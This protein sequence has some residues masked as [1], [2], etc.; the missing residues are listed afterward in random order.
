MRLADAAR[1]MLRIALRRPLVVIL[2][3][4]VA[5][6]VAFALLEALVQATDYGFPGAYRL[7]LQTEG[8]LPELYGYA[9]GLAITLFLFGAWRRWRLHSAAVWAAAYLYLTLDDAF[10][11]HER[12]GGVVAR[13]LGEGF[14]PAGLRTQD[15]GELMVYLTFGA[16]LLGAL[17]LVERRR[18]GATTTMLTRLMLPLIALLAYFA[19]AI[20]IAF[21]DLPMDVMIEDGG[22]LVAL[23]IT[24]A[25]CFIWTRRAAELGEELEGPRG[26]ARLQGMDQGMDQDRDQYLT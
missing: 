17:V 1:A 15:F 6:D 12:L 21:H 26:G 4:M 8:G 13:G 19:V 18:G 2:A 24:A 10:K 22:E 5:A 11:I 16:T 20:D 7:S 23:S 14:G 9:K 25:A 3:L